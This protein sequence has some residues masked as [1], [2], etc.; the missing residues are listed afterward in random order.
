MDGAELLDDADE[1]DEPE[2]AGFRPLDPDEPLC[3][4]PDPALCE[5]E[6]AEDV[7]ADVPLQDEVDPVD[8][9]DPLAPT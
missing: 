3:P 1:L 2:L 8:P 5:D 7:P 4:P 9:V 6:P